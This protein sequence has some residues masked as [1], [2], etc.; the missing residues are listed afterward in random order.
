MNKLYAAN[1]FISTSK[2]HNEYCSYVFIILD[3]HVK[4]TKESGWCNDPLNERCYSRISGYLAELI[5]SAFIYKMKIE[6]KKIL[7]VNTMYLDA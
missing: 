4:L 5:T 1:M 6:K 2:I 3:R 7:W